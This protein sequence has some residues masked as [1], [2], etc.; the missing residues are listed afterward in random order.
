MDDERILRRGPEES[1]ESALVDGCIRLGALR[2]VVLPLVWPGIVATALFA[3]IFSWNEFLFAFI[4][5]RREAVTLPVY[6]S[7]FWGEERG[8]LWGEMGAVGTVS[9]LPILLFA[10]VIQKYMIRGLTMG[11]VKG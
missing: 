1:D 3:M 7:T 4:L 2:R 9:M 11:A 6:I 5:T 10:I 8:T